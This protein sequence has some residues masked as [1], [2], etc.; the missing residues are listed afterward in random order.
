MATLTPFPKIQFFDDNGDPLAGGKVY[1]YEQ[2]TTTP[3]ATYQDEA[4]TTPN[5]N[6]VI[7]DSSGR[8]LIW[9]GSADYTFVIHNSSDV[10]QSSGGDVTSNAASLA[11][12]ADL[13]SPTFT[14]TPAAPTAAEGTNTTQIATTAFVETATGSL[15][16]TVVGTAGEIDVDSSDVNNPVL[17]LSSALFLE[18]PSGSILV[19]GISGG[20][21]VRSGDHIVTVG[22][23]FCRDSTNTEVLSWADQV[24][25]IPSVASTQYS[26]FACDD[27]TVRTDTDHEGA[28]LIGSYAIRYLF[29]VFTLAST[30][31]PDMVTNED[32][33]VFTNR[34]QTPITSGVT[35]PDNVTT[36]IDISGFIPSVARVAGIAVGASSATA[37]AYCCFGPAAAIV[38]Q[39]VFS[40]YQYSTAGDIFQNGT[41]F[42]GSDFWPLFTTNIYWGDG[43]YSN[44]ANTTTPH[45]YGI[46][47]NR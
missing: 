22:A 21:V 4:E 24:V 44:A 23:G 26:L 12:K 28:N 27:G 31:L 38:A 40:Q 46:K 47:F 43:S 13:V 32:S 11:L 29:T 18:T 3:L 16:E 20:K 10:L 14:G 37:N 9:L 5:T 6:P 17:S 45:L 30:I 36:A 8:A 15:V 39:T 1:T 42:S 25:T 2:G 35:V 33:V 34:S 41:S 19:G 7:L